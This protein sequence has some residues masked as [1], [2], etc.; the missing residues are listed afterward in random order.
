[1]PDVFR[2]LGRDDL[3]DDLI[4]A[5]LNRRVRLRIERDLHGRRVHV[6]GRTIPLLALATIHRQPDRVA[7][8]LKRLVAVEHGLH[9]IRAGRHLAQAV[10]GVAEH[11]RIDHLRRRRRPLLDVDA[12]ELLRLRA[13]VH[14]HSRL[15]TRVVREDEEQPSGRQRAAELHV[16]LH[17]ELRRRER[18]SREHE[19]ER[20]KQDR[21]HGGSSRQRRG[22]CDGR[23]DV[24][25]RAGWQGQRA[26]T[27]EWR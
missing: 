19:Q 26:A 10:A 25:C 23:Q 2:V 9:A 18:G 21:A 7:V 13:V 4:Y 5:K 3:G 20:G 11:A 15:V 14:L 27:I 24:V 17:G 16:V 8:A 22:S 12:E 6:P 1:M